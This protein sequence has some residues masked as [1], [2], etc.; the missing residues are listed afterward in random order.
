[1][2]TYKHGSRSLQHETN[3]TISGLVWLGITSSDIFGQRL[4]RTLKLSPYSQL[5]SRSHS[6]QSS[7]G[8]TLSEQSQTGRHLATLLQHEITP[9]RLTIPDHKTL[10]LSV[11]NRVKATNIL[12]SFEDN[13][14]FD[15]EEMDL[16]RELQLMLILNIKFEIQAVDEGGN[17]KYWLD[18]RLSSFHG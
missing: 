4:D 16:I 5:T 2:H 11:N 14:A 12:R 3:I 10:P 7:D 15:N 1:M 8:V 9:S 17:M 18:K 6:R 13:D